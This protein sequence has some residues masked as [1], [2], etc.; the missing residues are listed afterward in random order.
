M[1][2]AIVEGSPSPWAASVGVV[3]IVFGM[4]MAAAQGNELMVQTVIGPKT[5]AARNVPADC[6]PDEAAQEDVSVAECELMVAN[7]RMMIVSRPAWFR[8][9]Q[10]ILTLVN[11]LAAFASIVVGLALVGARRWAPHAAVVV[12][13]LL[14]A[15]DVVGFTG[16]FYTGPLLRAIYLWNIVVW[17]FIHMCLVAGAVAGRQADRAAG[18]AHALT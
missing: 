1:P 3:A 15:L 11:T 7:V 18:A 12:F 5:V 8:P 16:A 14:L 10:Q 2:Q 13:S 9:F 17:L 6:R 4:L